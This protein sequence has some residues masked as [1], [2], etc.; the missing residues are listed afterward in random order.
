MTTGTVGITAARTTARRR[1]RAQWLAPTGLILLGLIPVL[2]GAAR[3]T[4]L[5][6][7][8]V[9][10]EDARFLDSPIPVIT[11][12]V[13]ATLFSL[14]GAFQFV[15]AMRRG[16]W[17]RIA[18]LVLV[19]AGLAAALSGLWMSVFYPHPPGD[20]VALVALRLVFGCA[21]VASILI[22]IR[23]IARRDF[24]RHG[25]WM[26]RAYAIGAGAGTQAIVL[27][28]ESIAFGSTNELA[29]AVFMGA[30]WVINLAIAEFVIR[31]RAMRT[32]ASH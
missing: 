2:A 30:A 12:I 21:M 26:T 19:P 15:P 4:E 11:H 23:T 3:L 8:A 27:I 24:I 17:H 20:G 14:V 1:A 25:E 5:T 32:P 9:A 18:G 29:R 13:S 7:G 6:G 22:G 28:P 31:R 16:G 10:T